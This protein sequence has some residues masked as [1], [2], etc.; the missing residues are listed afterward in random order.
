MLADTSRVLSCSEDKTMKMWSFPEGFALFIYKGHT[1]GITACAFSPTSKWLVSGSDY[2]ERRIMLWD[3]S[4]V[5]APF[6]LYIHC[7][8]I[9]HPVAICG[10]Y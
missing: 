8:I 5:G 6:I 7:A 1:S 10:L 2:G 3:A 9:N 4:M